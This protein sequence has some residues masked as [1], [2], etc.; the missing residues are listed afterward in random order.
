M[1]QLLDA[2]TPV[3]R[4]R[5]AAAAAALAAVAYLAW[6]VFGVGGQRATMAVDD[7]GQLVAA[8]LAMSVC[9]MAARRATAARATWALLAVSAFLWGLG[10]AVWSWNALVM[11]TP[12]PFPS[13]ADVGFLT[14][15]PFACAALVL[16]PSGSRHTADRIRVILDG[17][18]IATALLFASWATL[19]GP[20]ARNEH[21]GLLAQ[22]IALSYPMSD[23]V[24]VSLV[25]ILMARACSRGRQ[26]LGLVM[27]G[28]VA[29]AVADSGFAYLTEVDR[30]TGVNFLDTGWVVG[31]LLIALGAF[32]AVLAPT[33][34]VD[35]DEASTVSMIAPYVPV[36]LV[37]MA[38]SVQL[39]RG[40]PIGT[41][42]WVM[43]L[44]LAV[45]VLAREFIR[46][47]AGWRSAH[48]ARGRSA[49]DAEAP[50]SGH[51]DDP[52]LLRG[53]R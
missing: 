19:L 1:S 23:V 6:V 51:E 42:S 44:A 30:Y 34:L 11:D 25:V 48:R 3:H 53:A 46:M 15:V 27:A 49:I 37:L 14:A 26:S 4:F 2:S 12:V 13:L 33:R 24:M 32:W 43:A 38:T 31:Y 18:I 29:F 41:V 52:V 16:Y 20:I 45:L 39:I 21:D 5:I 9:I 17:C 35:R 28:I 36:L 50:E 22:V 7:L 8:W 47:E 10:E 40:A